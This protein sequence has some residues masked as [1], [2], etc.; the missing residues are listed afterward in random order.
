VHS[1]FSQ[2]VEG[3]SPQPSKQEARQAK[4]QLAARRHSEKIT[5]GET[6]YV[7]AKENVTQAS[8]CRHVVMGKEEFQKGQEFLSSFVEPIQIHIEGVFPACTLT[9]RIEGAEVP[10][11]P[12]TVLSTE[13]EASGSYAYIMLANFSDIELTVP[14]VTAL[15]IAEKI[16]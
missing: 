12:S 8:R 9:N 14:K 15:F 5:Q 6:W 13:T 4:E 11:V 3:H 7:K 10:T 1:Q 16:S 2:K